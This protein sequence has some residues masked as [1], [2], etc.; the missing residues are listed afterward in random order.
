V[1]PPSKL[2]APRLPAFLRAIAGY[3]AAK[4]ALV[5]LVGLGFL[6]LIHRDLQAAGEELVRHFHLSPSSHYPRIFLELTAKV[7]D[8]WLWGL[9]LGSMLYASLRFAEAY[10]LWHGKAWAAWLGAVSGAIYVPFEAVELHRKVTILRTA[11]LVVNLL[12]V[13]YLLSVLRRRPRTVDGASE[14]RID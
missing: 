4:G 6:G 8:G 5:L 2:S 9:A 10:G 1:D 7:T 14:Y 3:E 11:S 13:G 12:V